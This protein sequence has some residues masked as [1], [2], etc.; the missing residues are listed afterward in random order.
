MQSVEWFRMR[1][2]GLACFVALLGLPMSSL[3]A[4]DMPQFSLPSVIDGKVV[5]SASFTG[6][7][8]LVTFFATWCAPCRQEIPVL[9]E[10]HQK[11][12]EKGF[13]VIALSVDEKGAGVVAE[14]VEQEQIK[15]PVLM[16]G[17][18]TPRKFGG[19]IGIPTSFLINKAGHVVKKYPGYI[20][21]SL[22]EKD[23]KSVL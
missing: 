15:Y 1:I 17:K 4:V 18:G 14:L 3:G 8:L 7:A 5:D 19:I 12:E 11:Y 16:A 6:K 9:K 21:H 20:A 22:L 23:I 10:L 2:L 13:S